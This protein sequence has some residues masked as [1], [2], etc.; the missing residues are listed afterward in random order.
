[1]ERIYQVTH[2]DSGQETTTHQESTYP[3]SATRTTEINSSQNKIEINIFDGLGR[4][5]ENQ[6]IS[7]PQGSVLIDTTYDALGRVATESNPYR[8]GNDGSSSPGTTTYGYD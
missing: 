8:A 4:V 1:M 5:T 7:Y 6:L 3:F 2:P